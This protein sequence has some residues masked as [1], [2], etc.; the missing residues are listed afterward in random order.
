MESL[1]IVQ[2]SLCVSALGSFGWGMAWFFSKP[3]QRNAYTSLVG[4]L[5]LVCAVW[6]VTVVSLAAVEPRRSVAAV[7]MYA[8]SLAT[9]WW[10]V[11]T[12]RRQSR[13]LTAICDADIPEYL[14]QDGPYRVVRHPFYSAYT[15]CW[16]A[17]WVASGSWL[18]LASAALMTATYVSGARMEEAKFRASP[19]AGDHADYCR[20]TG[21]M[22]P[23]LNLC[24]PHSRRSA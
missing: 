16:L 4:A 10:A 19:L 22:V 17:G 14:L 15:L 1:R 6:H 11:R 23:R 3:P 9:F 13:T 5:A 20:R 12:C 2:V 24:L 7:A 21:F 8:L 18:G